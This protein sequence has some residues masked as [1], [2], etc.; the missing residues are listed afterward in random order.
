MT[1]SL[2]ELSKEY[3]RSAQ[4][5]EERIAALQK[6]QKRT[7]GAATLEL[8]RRI[9]TLYYEML[10]ARRTMRHLAGYYRS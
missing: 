10:D 8:Q 6:K 2:E 3:H 1:A 5:L 9:D 7:K 4:L